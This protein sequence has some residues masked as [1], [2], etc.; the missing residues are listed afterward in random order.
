MYYVVGVLI[1]VV[2]AGFSAGFFLAPVPLMILAVVAVAWTVILY[3]DAANGP[4]GTSSGIG[5]GLFSLLGP[6]FMIGMIIGA[7]IG[8]GGCTAI[9]EHDWSSI[10]SSLSEFLLRQ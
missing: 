3:R 9:I 10:G 4:P 1:L 7:V 5:S 2:A 8:Y 6:F